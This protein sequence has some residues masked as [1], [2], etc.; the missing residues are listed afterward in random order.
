MNTKAAVALLS[1][2]VFAGTPGFAETTAPV[3]KAASDKASYTECTVADVFAKKDALAGKNIS[4]KGKVT[5][6]SGGI[7][8]TNW[9][10]IKDGTGSAGT[11]DFVVTSGDVAKV[12]DQVVVKGEL[13]KDVDFGYGY[14]YAV[15]IK[16]A[17][18]T[19]K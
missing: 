4:I 5:K 3:A 18:V 17:K 14:K 13:S 8:G 10:H 11:D 12:G 2:V 9:F 1:L 19:A 7:M 15:I 16:D 6:F